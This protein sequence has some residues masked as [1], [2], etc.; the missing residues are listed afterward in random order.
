MKP[1]RRRII[2]AVAAATL[3]LLGAMLWVMG[4]TVVIDRSRN[5]LSATI[6]DSGGTTQALHRLPGR[7]FYTI[8]RIEGAIAL[9]CRDGS[10]EQWSYVTQHMHSW[11]HVRPGDGCSRVV[12]LG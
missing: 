7:I 10:R 11:L 4:S 2:P 3:A 9:R 8:P 12:Q 5:V 1:V 6:T